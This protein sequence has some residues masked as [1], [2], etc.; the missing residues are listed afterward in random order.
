MIIIYRIKDIYI[1]SSFNI[2]SCKLDLDCYTSII[3]TKQYT[4]QVQHA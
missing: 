2:V 4:F 3:L 1:Y